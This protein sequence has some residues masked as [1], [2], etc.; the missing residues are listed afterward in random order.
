MG[1]VSIFCA[2]YTCKR[3]FMC[4]PVRV[5]SI[6]VNGEREPVCRACIEAAN[7]KR[8]ANGLEP[9]VPHP[10]AYEACHETELPLD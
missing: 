4:N 5:P 10:L 9:I 3:V 6:R 1:Y 7:P 8:I 2:C